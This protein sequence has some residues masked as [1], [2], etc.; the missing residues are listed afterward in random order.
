MAWSGCAECSVAQLALLEQD[1]VGFVEA[2]AAVWA[3]AQSRI[4][5]F[6]VARTMVGRAAQIAFANGV[7][8]ADVDRMSPNE[9][10]RVL[11]R[12]IINSKPYARS[13]RIG[14]S[15]Q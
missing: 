4:D 13:R 11:L 1:R 14:N 3:L 15:W 8:D 2:L 9:S 12:V 5:A 10:G 6:R 7:A